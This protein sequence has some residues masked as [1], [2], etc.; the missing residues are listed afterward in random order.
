MLKLPFESVHFVGIYGSGMSAIAQYLAGKGVV[1]T[2]SDRFEL[3][4]ETLKIKTSLEN[5]GCKI[6][7]QDGSG[8]NDSTSLICISTAIEATNPD[9]IK[10]EELGIKIVHRSDILAQ[11]IKNTRSIAI[12]GT[13]GKS[14][15]TAMIFEFLSACD[16]SPSLI[17]GAPIKR[18]EAEGLLGNAYIGDSELLIV[19]VDESD[20]SLV[21]YE[22]FGTVILNLSKDHKPEEEVLDMFKKLIS[23]SIWTIKN[24][25][26]P[27]LSTLKTD[28]NF[29]FN[30]NAEFPAKRLHTD[31][32]SSGVMAYGEKFITPLPGAHNSQ[33]LLAAVAVCMHLG[34]TA[35]GLAIAT[36]YFQG[37]DRRFNIYK[38]NSDIIVIDDFA[39]NPEKIKAA[40]KAAQQLSQNVV[41]IYQPHGYAPTKFLLEDYA[42][43]FRDILRPSDNLILL[44]IYYAGGTAIKNVTSKDILARMKELGGLRFE[45]VAVDDRLDGLTQIAHYIHEQG[46]ILLMGARDPGLATFRNQIINLL[47]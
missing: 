25:D 31:K 38:T 10:A 28:C 21:K 14:T 9:L 40:I 20:G 36:P 4:S 8:L 7:T 18:L 23:Q 30:Q 26:D 19:E 27:K 24:F 33:N 47:N 32:L 6:F 1:V 11:I 39:H 3:C 43:T 22:P 34:C 13:S 15:V 2:G 5:F 42:Q 17:T 29:G 35:T 45:A 16:Q 12:A 37:I 44:P 46:A 41:A